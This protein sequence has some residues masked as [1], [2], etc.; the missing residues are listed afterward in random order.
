MKQIEIYAIIEYGL[1]AGLVGS[2]QRGDDTK[3]QHRYTLYCVPGHLF[4]PGKHFLLLDEWLVNPSYLILS[5]GI[6]SEAEYRHFLQ[7]QA[8]PI[9]Q[10][11][12]FSWIGLY[13]A[14]E[15]KKISDTQYC[16][17]LFRRSEKKWSGY[18]HV[19]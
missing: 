11:L 18:I 3:M 1:I 6:M 15:S 2:A 9:Y 10:S 19:G 5:H 8:I 7:Q 16:G 4:T 13:P 14:H 12:S 17:K